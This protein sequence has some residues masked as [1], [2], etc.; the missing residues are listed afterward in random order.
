MGGPGTQ[1]SESGKGRRAVGLT[2]GSVGSPLDGY[3]DTLAA[4]TLELVGQL[5]E[6]SNAVF[7]VRAEGVP[8]VYKPVAG[9]RPLWDFPRGTLAMREVA[10]YELSAA[11]GWDLV[12][13]TVLRDG[14]FGVGSVQ[15][16]VG[17][18]PDASGIIT[19]PPTAD[20]LV[21]LVAES[22]LPKGWHPVMQAELRDGTDVFVAHADDARL[23]SLAVLDAVLNNADRKGS[24][25]LTDGPRI[26]G[27]DNGL[28]L[29]EVAKLRT[30]LWGWAGDPLPDTERVRVAR[31]AAALEGETGTL[32]G[33]LLTGAE[34]DALRTRLETLMDCGEHPLPPAEWPAI[35]WPP[36]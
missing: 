10:A 16:W 23:R 17:P 8:C 19:D 30:V 25:I 34:V 5:A 7:L 33:E 24:H 32:M 29:A 27:I 3:R 35:P 14:P 9:E 6:A 26:W 13:P 31:L 18:L 20:E 4:G 12:P 22:D 21:G 11:G 28:G 36:L 15:A 2:P 1:A